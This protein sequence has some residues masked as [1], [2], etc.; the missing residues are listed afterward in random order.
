ML[1][2]VL[3][4]SLVRIFG[5]VKI[6]NEG[7]VAR[8]L[9]KAGTVSGWELPDDENHGEQYRVCCPYCK[10][11]HFHLYI[12]YLS[13][14]VPKLEDRLMMHSDLLAICFRRHCLQDS[15]NRLD[16][17]R[18]IGMNIAEAIK[19]N[20]VT[21]GNALV[22]DDEPQDNLYSWPEHPDESGFRGWVPDYKAV[23]I[24]TPPCVLNYL[25]QRRISA[26]DVDMFHIG[27]GPVKSPTT[28][29]YLTGGAPWILIPIIQHGKLKGMQARALP[30]FCDGK[31]KYWLHPG[32]RKKTLIGN[33][34]NAQKLGIG[35]LSEGWFDV[36]SVGMPGVCMFGHTPS[37]YQRMLLGSFDYGLIWLPDTDVRPDLNPIAVAE[38]YCAEWNASGHFPKGAHVVKLPAKD[39]GEMDRQAVWREI[40]A[41]VSPEMR[42]FLLSRI[43]PRL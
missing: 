34:D 32:S 19:D 7:M 36:F 5:K 4:D 38:K 43:V 18:R 31:F 26:A 3:Y 12:S 37:S 40:C 13:F 8:I 20:V 27:W 11:R 24:D 14:A 42:E 10:D 21:A 28:G 33:L 2:P 16:L 25:R 29:D 35:V 6:E 15:V 9:P 17:L 30:E 22:L 23:N 1:N 41:Q 39:A